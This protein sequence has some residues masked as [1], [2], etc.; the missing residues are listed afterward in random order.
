MSWHN[1]IVN[2]RFKSLLVLLLMALLPLRGMAAA[3]MPC[4]GTADAGMQQHAVATPENTLCHEAEP[5]G[6]ADAGCAFCAVHCAGAVQMLIQGDPVLP[7]AGATDP[8]EFFARFLPGIVP[9]HLERP[10][11]CS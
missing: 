1:L 4:C 7:G 10:P 6:E 5:G 9:G 2:L 8:I 3:L 11:L